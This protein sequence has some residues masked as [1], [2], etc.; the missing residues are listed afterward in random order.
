[1]SQFDVDA[2]D[3]TPEVL[4]ATEAEIAK[5]RELIAV[6]ADEL[7]RLEALCAEKQATL[8]WSKLVVEINASTF[9][10][11]ALG[12]MAEGIA[13]FDNSL[14]MPA[15]YE[16][17][18]DGVPYNETDDYANFSWIENAVDKVLNDV[19]D[20]L[21]R[22]EYRQGLLMLLVVTIRVGELARKTE[23]KAVEEF[24]ECRDEVVDVWQRVIGTND[25]TLPE[26]V[27]KEWRDILDRHIGAP[28]DIDGK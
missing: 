5:L 26:K 27:L 4:S 11:T 8:S 24:E 3:L 10:Q 15:N 25:Y 18:S 19:E 28:F 6:K 22:N 20:A 17:D 23:M 9:A 2:A 13:Q 21:S 16:A 12:T 1:M 7:K 14:Q